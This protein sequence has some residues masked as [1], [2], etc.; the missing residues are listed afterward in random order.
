MLINL[1]VD[2]HAVREVGKINLP[3]L[4]A[5]YE[6]VHAIVRELKSGEAELDEDVE[7][8]EVYE[9]LQPMHV[10]HKVL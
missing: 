6:C 4:N 5:T 9:L 10:H 8:V 7:N 2:K 1:K 3:I